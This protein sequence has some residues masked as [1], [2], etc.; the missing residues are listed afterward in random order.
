[1]VSSRNKVNRLY[2]ESAIYTDNTLRAIAAQRA[3][4]LSDI[5]NSAAGSQNMEDED[6]LLIN[7][8]F[9]SKT[10]TYVFHAYLMRKTLKIVGT[11]RRTR[12][13]NVFTDKIDGHDL[14]QLLG[15]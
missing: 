11:W 12:R 13:I 5:L 8:L 15:S 6:L 7:E 10:G 2:Y 1:M 14:L 4:D 3:V 9:S